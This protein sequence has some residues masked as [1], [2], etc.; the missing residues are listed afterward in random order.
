MTNSFPG[1]VAKAERID[2]LDVLRGFALLGILAMNIQSFSMIGAAY[3]NPTAY[4]DLSGAN[5]WVWL[6]SHVLTDQKFMTIFSMLFGAGEREWP[7]TCAEPRGT[8]RR[9]QRMKRITTMTHNQGESSTG[10]APR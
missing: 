8:C 2:S 10:A 1:P 9:A 5:Y 7:Y 4:G 3:F 6:L